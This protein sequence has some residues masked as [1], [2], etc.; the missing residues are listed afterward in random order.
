MGSIVEMKEEEL[1]ILYKSLHKINPAGEPH[2]LSDPLILCNLKT[3]NYLHTHK[4]KVPDSKLLNE[5][6]C[7]PFNSNHIAEY[8]IWKLV[9]ADPPPVPDLPDLPAS[10]LALQTEDE[11]VSAYVYHPFTQRFLNFEKGLVVGSEN[12]KVWR[13]SSYGRR[14]NGGF[15][16]IECE[17]G[18]LCMGESKGLLPNHRR[19]EVCTEKHISHLWEVMFINPDLE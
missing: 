8:D 13:V 2:H 16:R 4:I 14:R 6:S 15:V 18:E 1:D 10:D 17:E 3:K 5:V 7:C 12:K 11:T 19:L 9:R